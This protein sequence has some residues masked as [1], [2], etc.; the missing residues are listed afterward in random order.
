MNA[1]RTKER[2]ETLSTM[3]LP[4]VKRAVQEEAIKQDRSMGYVIERAV[5]EYLGRHAH[6][7]P[8]VH[9]TL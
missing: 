6:T 7:N 5:I 8:S 4:S 1:P 3:L 2:R 9:T